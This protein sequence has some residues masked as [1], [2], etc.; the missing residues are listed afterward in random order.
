MHSNHPSRLSR[1]P[2]Y[3]SAAGEVGAEAEDQAEQHVADRS[4]P[5]AGAHQLDALHTEGRE[6]RERSE[7]SDAQEESPF[8]FEQ[9][10]LLGEGHQATEREASEH[11]DG[12]GVPW[13]RLLVT[14][15]DPA[16][17][18]VAGDG[19]EGAAEADDK[20]ANHEGHP[21]VRGARNKTRAGAGS[22]LRPVDIRQGA[23]GR[24]VR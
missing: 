7:D 22:D 17:K 19:T 6:G 12:K 21:T 24:G 2:L 18:A 9:L 16:G 20:E 3:A 4:I 23:P 10:A 8:A 14:A 13:E 5:I 1:N 15:L 11:V